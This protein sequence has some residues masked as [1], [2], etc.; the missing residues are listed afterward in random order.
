M[1]ASMF[2]AS[3]A[4][5]LSDQLGC[6]T[7]R[8]DGKLSL[9]PEVL[10]AGQEATNGLKHIEKRPRRESTVRAGRNVSESAGRLARSM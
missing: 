7:Y 1:A 6:V 2:S 3:R 5:R 9:Q 4:R 8:L 10:G